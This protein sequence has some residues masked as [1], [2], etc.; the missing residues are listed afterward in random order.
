MSENIKPIFNKTIIV[1][2]EMKF[3]KEAAIHKFKLPNNKN[4]Q[5]ESL[6]DS[7]NLPNIMTAGLTI[8]NR[9][10]LIKIFRFPVENWTLELPGGEVEKAENFADAA[11]RE[12][13]EEVG[14]TSDQPFEEL[15]RGWLYNGKINTSFIIFFAKNCKKV[16]EPK[17]DDVERYSGLEVIEE[18]PQD[19]IRKITNG[20]IEYDPAISHALI[21][22]IGKGIIK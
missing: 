1:L 4:A 12:F 16:T 7:K 3:M 20:N 11:K 6:Y 22:L 8:K 9:L 10:V 19:I 14:Y 17:L 5:W 21:G 15:N 2:P 13:L 18:K